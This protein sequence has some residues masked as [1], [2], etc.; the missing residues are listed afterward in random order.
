ML[1]SKMVDILELI[2]R[3]SWLS[4]FLGFRDVFVRLGNGVR[5]RDNPRIQVRLVFG[6]SISFERFG[7]VP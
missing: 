4:Y 5:E 2:L 7:R 3:Y 1:E 6:C